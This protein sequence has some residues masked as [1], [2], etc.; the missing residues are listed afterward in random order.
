MPNDGDTRVVP[1][2]F[3]ALGQQGSPD[4]GGK[5]EVFDR[6]PA[7][8]QVVMTCDE[9][10]AMCPVTSQADL[11]TLIITYN[12]VLFCIESKSLK[13]YLSRLRNK[14]VFC[15]Q[16]AYDVAQDIYDA[17]EA[18][19]VQVQVNQKSRGG[20]RIQALALLVDGQQMRPVENMH[21]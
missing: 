2:K 19:Q 10:T 18:P 15:E 5:L 21:R 8:T 14:G 9:V 11:Y 20:I 12:P 7:I 4:L 16:L 6:P 1:L 3:K 17:T 13:L